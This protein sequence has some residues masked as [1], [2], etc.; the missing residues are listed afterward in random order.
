MKLKVDKVGLANPSVP[1]KNKKERE[2][3]GQKFE[4]LIFFQNLLMFS[5]K[6]Y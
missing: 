5:Q 1:K 2:W 3:Y 6:L 4:S